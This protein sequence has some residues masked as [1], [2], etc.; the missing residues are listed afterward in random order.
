MMMKRWR[1]SRWI[2]LIMVAWALCTIFMGLVT[3]YAGLLVV[4]AALGVAEGGLFPV[5]AFK[6]HIT[7]TAC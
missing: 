7:N 1:P 2:P 4:R 3:N 6:L 5:C